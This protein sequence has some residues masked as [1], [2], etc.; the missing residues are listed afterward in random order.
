MRKL[1]CSVAALALLA[2]SV[3]PAAPAL[4]QSANSASITKDFGCGGFVPS[5]TGGFASGLVSFDGTHSVVTSS[6]V[7]SLVCHFD[8]PAGREPAKATHAEGFRCGTFMGPTIDS[9]MV[10]SPGGRA[11]LT[12]KINGG[13]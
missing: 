7:T 11:T 6:G 5:P 12:C 4:A 8:I 2:A 13:S 1:S 10:A 9:K 3:I